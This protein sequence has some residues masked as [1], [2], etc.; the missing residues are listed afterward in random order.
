MK[1]LRGIEQ[2]VHDVLLVQVC[3]VPKDQPDIVIR[4]FNSLPKQCRNPMGP[5]ETLG[6]V[7]QD[8]LQP[9]DP[10]KQ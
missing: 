5:M 9:K 8:I 6:L 10:F 1:I 7:L 2:L 3:D 4:T